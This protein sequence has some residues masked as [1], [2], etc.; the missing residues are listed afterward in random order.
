MWLGKIIGFVLGTLMLGPVGGLLGLLAGHFFDKGLVELDRHPPQQQRAEAQHVFYE[1]VFLLMGHLAKA[2][3][4]ISEQE[5]AQAEGFMTQMGLTDEHRREAIGLFK[6]GAA[7]DF[8][9]DDTMIRF[10]SRCGH[11]RQL[12]RVLLEYLFHI[13]FADGELHAAERQSLEKIAG[14][15]G[16]TGPL[17]EQL[18]RMYHAQYGFA[19]GAGGGRGGADHLADAYQALGI[20]DSASDRELKRAYRKLM[21]EHHPDKLIAQGVPEDMLKVATEKSQ[22]I[23]AAYDLIVKMRAAA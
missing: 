2:D 1:T 3:G 8:S 7:G 21:S 14:W 9:I 20:S 4:H 17:F 12:Q 6:Q 5:V 15:L 10:Q 22:E 16:I 13:A 23:S 11:Y 19:A 18:L